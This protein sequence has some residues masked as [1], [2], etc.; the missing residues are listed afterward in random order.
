MVRNK[1]TKRKVNEGKDYNPKDYNS[2]DGIMTSIFGP[3]TWHLLH[4]ISFNYPANLSELEKKKYKDFVLSLQN[5]LPCGKCRS[6]LKKNF[7]KCPLNESSLESRDS[8]S[9]Y[10]YNLHETVNSMLNKKSGLTYNDVRDMYESFR[11]RCSTSVVG[12]KQISSKKDEKGCVI[13]FNGVKKKCVLR[14]VPMTDKCKSF[15]T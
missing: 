8:F 10:I 14:V 7:K 12:G 6:N 2:N 9:R 4:S 1:T 5:V 3:A 13:P 15:T 11:A